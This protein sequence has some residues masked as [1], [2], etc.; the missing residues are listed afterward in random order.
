MSITSLVSG[1]SFRDDFV[2][3]KNGRVSVS[4]LFHRPSAP[5]MA[6]AAITVA[7]GGQFPTQRLFRPV[8]STATRRESRRG[9]LKE[10]IAERQASDAEI[11]AQLKRRTIAA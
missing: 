4:E 6:V 2:P 7:P 8:D 9:L 11:D 5:P 3:T 1:A 10:L